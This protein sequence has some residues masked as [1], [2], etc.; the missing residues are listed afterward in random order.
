MEKWKVSL[1][2]EIII[3]QIGIS[4]FTFILDSFEVLDIPSLGPISLNPSLPHV[5]EGLGW[6][7][8]RSYM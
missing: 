1:L 5:A 8:L 6:G 2:I 3:A 7:D 4:L